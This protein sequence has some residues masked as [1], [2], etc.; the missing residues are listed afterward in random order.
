MPI[1]WKLEPVVYFERMDSVIQ[2][3][4]FDH[5][6][7]PSPAPALHQGSG[8][9]ISRQRQPFFAGARYE[10]TGK[11]AAVSSIVARGTAARPSIG[12]RVDWQVSTAVTS[13]KVMLCL[14]ASSSRLEETS[15]I[16]WDSRCD[17]WKI[18]I[19]SNGC[20]FIARSASPQTWTFEVGGGRGERATRDR[21][22]VLQPT[23]QGE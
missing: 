8:R 15:R 19:L 1:H 17:D 5:T 21:K 18:Y 22:R 6:S 11:K 9:H 16:I 12:K 4:S 23:N 2:P 10:L 20:R 13:A 14:S 3:I 7:W